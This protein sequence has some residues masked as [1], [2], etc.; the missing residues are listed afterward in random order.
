MLINSEAQRWSDRQAPFT[1][2]PQQGIIDMNNVTV[3][4]AVCTKPI[5]IADVSINQDV[6]GR[7][8][9]NDL[10][11]AAGGQRR[12]EPKNWL[13]NQ[14]TQELIEVIVNTG[15]SVISPITS[16]RGC[17]GG[18]YVCKELVY[19]YATWVS[20]EFFLKVIRAYDALVSGDVEKAQQVVE[21]TVDDRTPLRGI[22]NRIMGKYGMTYQA[23][24]KL[25][26]KEFGVKHIDELSPKQTSE[27]IEY[28]AGKVIEGDFIGKNEKHPEVIKEDIGAFGAG[29]RYRARVII[30][31][32]MSGSCAEM[33]GKAS[34]MRDMAWGIANDLG[35]RPNGMTHLPAAMNKL[36]RIY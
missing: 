36:K 34:T 5:V 7:H 29:H 2:N 14:Q 24:Y 27:A 11:K 17:K 23:V 32:D 35:F 15:M 1:E 6:E 10:H 4:Q 25:V 26:H 13:N 9:L 21:T 31:D 3:N 18:T 19:A 33:I 8:S 20:A 22:V 12:H 16:K 30:Y 28:L